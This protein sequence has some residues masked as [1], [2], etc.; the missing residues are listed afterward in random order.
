MDRA[1]A[2]WVAVVNGDSRLR[3]HVRRANADGDEAVSDRTERVEA[4]VA[5]D[6][7]L[8][9]ALAA[10]LLTDYGWV[11]VVNGDEFVGVLTPDAIY[12]ALRS[13]LDEAAATPVA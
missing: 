1:G 7:Y 12:R 2:D 11:A 6:D 9:N 3:G 5:I 13:S 8:E 4:W 10:M